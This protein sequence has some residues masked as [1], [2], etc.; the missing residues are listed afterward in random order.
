M[1]STNDEIL[2]EKEFS[3]LST[4]YIA[5]LY[6]HNN[7]PN[8]YGEIVYKESG[9]RVNNMKGFARDFLKDYG[10]EVPTD[11]RIMNTHS[12]IKEIIEV[13]KNNKTHK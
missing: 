7:K 11:A 6:R 13:L 1:L 3:Y 2:E 10:I 8:V 4:C 9:E 5:R 12:A